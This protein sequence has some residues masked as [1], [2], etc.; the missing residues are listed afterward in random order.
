MAHRFHQALASRTVDLRTSSNRT[1]ADLK[2]RSARPEGSHAASWTLKQTSDVRHLPVRR[3]RRLLWVLW[4]G[5]ALVGSIAE[6]R[7]WEVAR[8]RR[9]R[10]EGDRQAALSEIGVRF[11]AG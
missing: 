4:R 11:Y 8:C 2:F 10:P 6:V 3:R 7:Y 9:D 1:G 5:K